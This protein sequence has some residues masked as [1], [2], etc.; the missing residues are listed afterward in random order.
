MG[1][2]TD[3]DNPCL[4]KTGPDG[5]QACYLVLSEEERAKGFIRPVRRSYQHVGIAGPQYPLRDLTAEEHELYDEH[6]YVQYE[7]YPESERPALGRFWKQAELD[8][9]GKGCG[10]VTSMGRAL[11]ETYARQPSF[12]GAT[13]C[14][15]CGTHLPVGKDGEF[16]W[17]DDGTRVGS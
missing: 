2:T 5:Q 3:K 6:G 13:F 4:K 1:L 17:I 10:A 16:I 8:K 9:I 11:A 14:V 15:G 12:Y 7:E